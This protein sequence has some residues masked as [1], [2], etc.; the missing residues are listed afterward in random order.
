MSEY[1]SARNANNFC[2]PLPPSRL[3]VNNKLMSDVNFVLE[4]LRR[5]GR[6]SP[7]GFLPALPT[8]HEKPD[9]V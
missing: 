1:R 6:P 5:F 7:G 3:N 9:G 4:R 8:D 2:M